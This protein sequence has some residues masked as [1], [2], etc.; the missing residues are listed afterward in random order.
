M[1]KQ[2]RVGIVAASSVVPRAELELGVAHLRDNGFDVRVH[3]DVL[4]QHFTFAGKD[5][6]RAGS[7]FDFAHDPSLDVV[8]MA[9]GGYG[10][11]RLLPLLDELTAR[12]GNPPRKLLVGYSDVTALHE[13]VRTR[14]GWPTLHAP[15]PAALSFSRLPAAE[16]DAIVACVRGQRAAFPWE[17]TKLTF[18][19]A[20]PPSPIDGDLIGGNLSLWTAVAGTPYAA[21]GAGKLLFF[22]DVGEKPYRVDRMVTQLLQSGAFDG[23]AGI[24]LG[25]FTDCEDEDTPCL[26]PLPDGADPRTLLENVEQRTKVSLRRVYTLDESVREIFGTVGERLGIPIA[27]GLPVGHGPNFSPLPLGARYRL[28]ASGRLEVLNWDWTSKGN[29]A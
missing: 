9:R 19:T 24:I 1:N 25:D 13:Y 3:G 21:S 4:D 26:E 17:S 6:R 2:N 11:T 29:A 20:P 22:E 18:L 16:W 10:A 27:K 14:W 8:W 12:R 15:M 23:A 28:N 7:L 5:E